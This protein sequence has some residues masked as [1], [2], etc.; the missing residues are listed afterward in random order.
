MTFP[1]ICILSFLLCSGSDQ[2]P[3][4]GEHDAE[5]DNY[6][7][8][9][10]DILGSYQGHEECPVDIK[11]WAR[12]DLNSERN[13]QMGYPVGAY[14]DIEHHL[15]RLALVSEVT[16]RANKKYCTVTLALSASL[17]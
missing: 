16:P 2:T 3:A 15:M 7:D 13:E 5:S 14:I 6:G 4:A 1:W 8:S 12:L 11:T 9:E 17:L 10:A